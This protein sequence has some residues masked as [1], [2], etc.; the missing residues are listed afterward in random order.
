MR[1]FVRRW[2]F[3]ALLGVCGWG[4]AL[5]EDIS[6]IKQWVGKYPLEKIVNDKTLWEQPFV[7][8][9]LSTTM[10]ARFFAAFQKAKHSPEAP[11][12]TDGKGHFV[13]WSCNEPDDCG[14]NNMT[15]YFNTADGAAE[16][17]WRSP[18]GIG[19]TVKDF[20]LTKGD[21]R[22]LPPNGCG[23]GERDPFASFKR[24]GNGGEPKQP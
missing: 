1:G 8:A 10:G 15:V 22:P 14:G 19:G 3:V 16:V 20:W 9:A 2:L 11:V 12:A 5:A 7:L 17:C 4:S 13:V 21:A 23:V 6:A 18:D 24:Y